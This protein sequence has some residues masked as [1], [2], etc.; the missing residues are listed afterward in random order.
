MFKK[1]DATVDKYERLEYE[2]ANNNALIT[3]AVAYAKAIKEYRSLT[4]VDLH[5]EDL[6][7]ATVVSYP[8]QTVLHVT[9]QN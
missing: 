4:A 5:R 6:E 8:L 2:L 1:L 9:L 7:A 3:D